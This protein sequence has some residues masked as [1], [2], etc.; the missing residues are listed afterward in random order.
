MN[1]F[2]LLKFRKWDLQWEKP[3]FIWGYGVSP[4]DTSGEVKMEGKERKCTP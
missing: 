1:R 2:N 3:S 4:Y